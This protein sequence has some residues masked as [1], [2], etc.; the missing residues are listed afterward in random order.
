[1]RSRTHT[2][3]HTRRALSSHITTRTFVESSQHTLLSS[4]FTTRFLFFVE[5]STQP[6][7]R[8]VVLF[9]TASVVELEPPLVPPCLG[10][11]RVWTASR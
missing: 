7:V 10:R 8:V 11:N 1:M 9:K 3:T 4:L 2:H 5:S 6:R